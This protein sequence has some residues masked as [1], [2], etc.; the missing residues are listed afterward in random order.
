MVLC[1]PANALCLFSLGGDPVH[2]DFHIVYWWSWLLLGRHVAILEL[3]EHGKPAL[4]VLLVREI[5]RQTCY[6]E[7]A[8]GFCTRVTH[9]TVLGE[10]LLARN[11]CQSLCEERNDEDHS[12]ADNPVAI[13]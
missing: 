4:A 8:H 5:F 12:E 1:F 2:H 11:L 10:Q 3:F 7:A 9:L 6:G 13:G